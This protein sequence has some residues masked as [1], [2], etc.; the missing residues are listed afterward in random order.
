MKKIV[1][2]F[3][4]VFVFFVLKSQ[5][6][7]LADGKPVESIK[8][9]EFSSL[10]VRFPLTMNVQKFDYIE[11]LVDLSS[12]DQN[13]Y[14]FY[15]GKGAIENLANRKTFEAYILNP[16]SGYGDFSFGDAYISGNDLCE[17][18]R[19]QG[20]EKLTVTVEMIG[21][22]I[23]KYEKY[24]DE[25]REKW[26][27]KPIYDNGTVLIKGD[28]E[29]KQ[30]PPDKNFNGELVAFE[31]P[32][33]GL[34]INEEYTEYYFLPRYECSVYNKE[35]EM[36]VKIIMVKDSELEKQRKYQELK[37]I[38]EQLTPYE[39][40]KSDIMNWL[41]YNTFG[42]D[43]VEN[44]SQYDWNAIFGCETYKNLS[45][46]PV[47]KGKKHRRIVVAR[48]YVPELWQKKKI[49]KNEWETLILPE[50][51]LWDNVKDG[52]PENGAEKG[53]MQIFML[54][55]NNLSVIVFV[56]YSKGYN[57]NEFAPTNEQKQ[58]FDKILNTLEIKEI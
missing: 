42:S 56:S 36:S 41:G 1:L 15:E 48:Y 53:T 38:N 23:T 35:P 28:L 33:P 14:I 29:I 12:I 45:L 9:G 54:H 40:L 32:R 44:K 34:K 58:M 51:Y 55:K 13:A 21:Y 20:L 37:D 27:L 2:I 18:P 25:S 22:N 39:F 19:K 50:T 26:L 10:K 6:V 11:I 49:G 46:P 24:W 31:M 4:F 8:C 7:F 3:G 47:T 52:V 43:W 57:T 16:E 5:V 30:L 17:Y